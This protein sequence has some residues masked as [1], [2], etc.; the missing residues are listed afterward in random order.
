MK[1]IFFITILSIVI[2][3]CKNEENLRPQSTKNLV[4][5][6]SDSLIYPEE[7]YFKSL[8]QITFGGDN[9]E[10]YWSFD[11]KQLVFQSNNTNWNVGCD[12]MFLMNADETFK[13]KMPPM[14]STGKGRTTCAYFL[15]DNKHIIYAS[16]HLGDEACP[17]T[18]LKKDGKYI[19][20]IYDSYDIFVAD[21]EGNITAQL[22]NEIGYDAEPT[23]SPKGDKIVFTST[24]NGDIDLY[25]MNLDGSDV[26]QITFELGYDGGAF[27]SPDGTKIIFRSSRPKTDEAIAE[28][29]SLLEEGLVQ[30][31]EM[32]LYICN[33]DGS[34]LRQL[35][36]LGNANWSPFFLPDGKRII[37]SSNFEAERGFPFNLYIIGIDGKGLERVTHSE[38][39]D[40]F[41]VFSND[42]KKL[43]FSSNR[44]NGGGR[45]TNLFIAEWQD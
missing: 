27:F 36:N 40:A 24:R 16:T 7:K 29:K 13:D 44:N 30:P 26:K 33:A 4:K 37:F 18:P 28:Y 12:Q 6:A 22:T 45:D 31:T 15:P 42:G 10:A 1:H 43:I 5:T 8:K 19:W 2:I 20:P 25:T 32:E 34:D 41:P 39:F 3:S 35:T 23:V 11:D 9:A 38:T 14:I 21:L 17:E